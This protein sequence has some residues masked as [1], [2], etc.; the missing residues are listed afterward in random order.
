MNDV[1][2]KRTPTVAETI[3]FLQGFPSEY[4][5]R[6]YEGEGGAQILVTE[7]DDPGGVCVSL[8]TNE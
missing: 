3:L 6:G 4:K 7:N 1:D 8:F 5:V 2:Y